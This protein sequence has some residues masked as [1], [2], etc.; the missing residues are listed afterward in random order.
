MSKIGD[1]QANVGIFSADMS[2]IVSYIIATLLIITAIVLAIIAFIPTKPDD[3]I[4]DDI[5]LT[6]GQN[7]QECKDE[8]ARCNKKKPNYILLLFLILIP[9]AIIIVLFSKWWDHYVKTNRT[10]AQVGGTMFEIDTARDL[11]RN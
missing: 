1:F 7:S 3:C 9:I 11:L 4:K 2:V 6:E 8:T 5:C 10:A